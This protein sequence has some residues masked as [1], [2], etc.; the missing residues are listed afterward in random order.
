LLVFFVSIPTVG[1]SGAAVDSFPFPNPLFSAL[2][3]IEVL[4][5]YGRDEVDVGWIEPTLTLGTLKFVGHFC[6][7]KYFSCASSNCRLWSS[8]QKIRLADLI[9]FFP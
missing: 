8:Q 6:L 7:P 3:T 9:T 1:Q 4:M 5:I 2:D